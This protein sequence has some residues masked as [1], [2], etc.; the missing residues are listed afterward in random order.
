MAS[1]TERLTM[2]AILFDSTCPVKSD[3]SF[4]HGI[5]PER[6]W[7]FVPSLEDL[8]WAAQFFGD[9]EDAHRLE[10]C[11]LQVGWDAQFDGAFPPGVCRMCGKPAEWLDP[12]HGLCNECDAI[13]TDATLAGQNHRAGLGYTVY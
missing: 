8:N 3:R 13:S 7:P 11:A 9:L 12:I 10:E 5:A 6:R 1:L 2:N 4:G